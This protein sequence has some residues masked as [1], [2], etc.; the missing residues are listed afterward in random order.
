MSVLEDLGLA[1]WVITGLVTIIGVLCGVIRKQHQESVVV[2]E[3][4]LKEREVLTS[5][6]AAAVTAIGGITRSNDDRNEITD[7]L[8]DAISAQA[9]GF[10]LLKQAVTYMHDANS[11]KL[12]AIIKVIESLADSLRNIAARPSA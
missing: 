12:G 2:N 7:E 6:L 4:R 9:S 10:E 8:S 3:A 5:A 11:E 1:G